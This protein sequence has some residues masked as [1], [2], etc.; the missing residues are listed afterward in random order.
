LAKYEIN[1]VVVM[2]AGSAAVTRDAVLVYESLGERE[3]TMKVLADAPPPLIE[4]LSRQPDVRG[5]QQD[6]RFQQLLTRRTA[7][8]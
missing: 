8:P 1:Q 2:G 5:L 7:Q 3:M 4:D 6:P